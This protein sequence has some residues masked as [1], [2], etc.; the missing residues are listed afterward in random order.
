MP[1]EY[2]R[3]IEDLINRLK[4]DSH[5]PASK[6][7]PREAVEATLSGDSRLSQLISISRRMAE[8]RSLTPLLSFAIDSVLPIVGAERGY[9]VLIK[10]DKTLDYRVK[11]HLDGTEIKSEVDPISHSVLNEVVTTQKG[12]VIRNAIMDP[13]FLGSQSVMAM[14]LRSI[15]CVPLITQNNLIGAIYVENRAKS[16]RFSEENLA[17]LEF[18]ANQAAVS[19]ENANLNENLE[20]LVAERTQE[21]ALAKE[22]AEA[23][24]RAKSSF[25]SKISHELRTPLNA[26]INFTGFVID[27]YYGEVNREQKEALQRVIDSGNHLLSLINDLLDLNKI[28]AG[29]VTLDREPALLVELLDQA[30]EHTE[31]LIRGKPITVERKYS[32]DLPLIWID[33]RRVWQILLNIISNAVKYTKAGSITLQAQATEHEIEISVKDTGIGI[34]TEDKAH[35]F[36]YFKQGVNTLDNVVSSGLGLA[37]AKQLVELHQGE[38][39]FQSEVNL[40]TTFFIRL[41]RDSRPKVNSGSETN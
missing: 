7:Q 21:L 4:N 35:V 33:R 11:R 14:Q 23:A 5:K 20:Q 39:W 16:G 34:A 8:M 25:L 9:I 19:I 28:E 10:E 31:A 15:M 40:G 24:T 2:D 41:P 32:P 29:V 17:P 18:F 27:D 36:E 13:R 12:I 38:I 6:A 1:E 3:H 37:I 26:I 30:A 22:E